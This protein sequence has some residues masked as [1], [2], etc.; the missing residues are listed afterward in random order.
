MRAFILAIALILAFAAG[1]LSQS[2]PLT[3]AQTQMAGVQLWKSAGQPSGA[4]NS[5]AAAALAAI[6]VLMNMT[7]D[8][9]EAQYGSAALGG[10]Q[11]TVT[12]LFG[13]VIPAPWNTLPPLDQDLAGAVY[14]LNRFNV[15]AQMIQP[16]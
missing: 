7:V 3:P 13:F 8:Q 4:T 12:Q 6:D 15:P 16:P 5:D 2:P 10:T 11:L 14:M 9:V 1:A